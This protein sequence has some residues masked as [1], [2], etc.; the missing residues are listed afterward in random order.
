MIAEVRH[1]DPVV[2]LDEEQKVAARRGG[3][4]QRLV[5][6]KA[7]RL[8][9]ALCRIPHQGRADLV[10]S[11]VVERH[12]RSDIVA[13]DQRRLPG[14]YAL[15]T[16]NSIASAIERSGHRGEGEQLDVVVVDHH[17]DKGRSV[18]CRR[19]LTRMTV[20]IPRE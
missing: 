19:G 4:Q 2:S 16:E 12:G 11:E 13:R 1:D 17:G 18:G 15:V 14:G 6:V 5:P 7:P 3:D 8:H 20:R 9:H 10:I